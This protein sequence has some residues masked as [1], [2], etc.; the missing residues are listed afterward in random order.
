MELLAKLATALALYLAWAILSNSFFNQVLG[1]SL[2]L[3]LVLL[4]SLI[5]YQPAPTE[6]YFLIVLVFSLAV[7]CVRLLPLVQWLLNSRSSNARHREGL[8]VF[9][10]ERDDSER[11]ED[12]QRPFCAE[13][14]PP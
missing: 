11:D 12:S 10:S 3:F 4:I 7:F 14:V 6:A 2:S 5:Y 1:F 8:E 13:Y 9:P